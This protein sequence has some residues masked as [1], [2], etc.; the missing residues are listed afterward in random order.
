MA[1]SCASYG[2]QCRLR[3]VTVESEEVGFGL[4][5][6]AEYV[7]V[8]DCSSDQECYTQTCLNGPCLYCDVNTSA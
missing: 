8:A 3:P 6:G 7:C 4:S 5:G 2:A 1:T